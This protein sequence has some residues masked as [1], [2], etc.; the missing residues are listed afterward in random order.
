MLSEQLQ[1]LDG[2]NIQS[3]LGSEAAVNQLL[4]LIDQSLEKVEQLDT[5][6]DKCDSILSVLFLCSFCIEQQRIIF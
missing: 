2:A 4:N 3:M 1:F 6:L 5:E